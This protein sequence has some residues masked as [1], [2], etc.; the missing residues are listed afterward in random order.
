MASPKI[1]VQASM[2]GCRPRG[3]AARRDRRLAAMK[4][5]A[6]SGSG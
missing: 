2:P 4:R 3:L 5:A 6:E 1:T